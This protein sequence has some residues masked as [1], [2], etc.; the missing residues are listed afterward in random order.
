M[1]DSSALLLAKRGVILSQ[2]FRKLR[3]WTD[4]CQSLNKLGKSEAALPL[5]PI[6][7]TLK[8][9]S[10]AY[11][12]NQ[13]GE[14]AR[15]Q[16][17]TFCPRSQWFLFFSP[18]YLFVYLDV[19][20]DTYSYVLGTFHITSTTESVCNSLQSAVRKTS[21]GKPQI[22]SSLPEVTQTCNIRLG[23]FSPW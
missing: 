13:Q 20:E 15:E 9:W 14:R 19:K 4:R 23:T 8:W 17:G 2:G 7:A 10:F 3:G 1:R 18:K 6:K 16:A 12:N 22:F 21:S 5:I 11:R